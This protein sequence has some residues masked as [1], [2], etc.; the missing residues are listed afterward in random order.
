MYDNYGSRL[1][2]TILHDE[3]K[4]N[5][6]R[7][8][9]V[10]TRSDNLEDGFIE[11]TFEQVAR[12][13]NHVSHWLQA[14]FENGDKPP[15]HTTLSYIGVPDLRYNIL[16]YAAVQCG[17]KV[18]LPSP[19]NPAAVNVSLLEQTQCSRLVHSVEVGP[20]A[21]TLQG[22]VS[23][24][25]CEQLPSLNELLAASA[26]EYTY[27]LKYA[28]VYR[29][30]ILIL[31]SS[32]STGQPKPVVHTHGTFA[33]YDVRDWPTVPGRINHD[34]LCTLRFSQPDSRIYDAFP[35]FHIAGFMT[36][37]MVPLFNLTAP[38]F[39][40]PLRPPSGAL[41]AEMIRLHRPRGAIIPPSITEQLYHE[42]GGIDLFKQLDVLLFAGGPLPQV[43]GDEIS[44][45][46][47]LCQLYGSTE[48]SQIRQ[49]IPL[50]EDWS[51]IQFHPNEPLELQP[52]GD[53]MFE[54]VVF[55]DK[56]LERTSPLYHNYPDMREWRTKDLFRPHPSKPDLWKFH[57]RRDDIL[58]F[59]SGEKLNPIPMESSIT[60]VSG[61]NG[62]LVVGQGHPRAALLVEL[63]RDVAFSSDPRQEL[64]SAIDAANALLPGYGRI[65]RSMIIIADAKKPF[66]RAG[67]GTVVRRL[68]EELYAVEIQKFYETASRKLQPVSIALKPSA[69]RA[70][71]VSGLVRSILSQVS[72]DDQ[73][74]DEE[75]FYAHGM[76]SVKTVEA[77]W[78]L[79]ASLLPYKSEADL[80]WVSAEVLYRSP[81]IK[82]LSSLLL[83][84]LNNG[85]V[86]KKRNRVIEMQAKIAE[87]TRDLPQNLATLKTKVDT[88][89][90]S[91][92]VTGTTGYLGGRLLTEL[93]K[94]PRISR[95]Y[96][97][98]RSTKAQQIFEKH[99]PR[100]SGDLVF[101]HVN[102]ASPNLGLSN[103]NYTR[104]LQDCDIIVH[105]AWRVDFNLTLNSFE[106]NLQSVKHL[107]GLSATSSLRP[108]ILFISS[109][110]STGVFAPAGSPQHTVPEDIVEDLGATMD[111]GYAESK[112]VAEHV[113]Y[114]ASKV[115]IPSTII[116][117]GQISPSSA[118]KEQGTWPDGDFVPVFLRTCKASRVLASDFVD[119][120]NWVPVDQAAIIV[121]DIM[122]HEVQGGSGVRFY[123]VVHPRPRPWSAVIG[124]V[125]TWCGEGTR[126]VS[127]QKWLQALR[128]SDIGDPQILDRFP[129]LRMRQVYD[130]MAQRG[131]THEYE[132]N[133]LM[134]TSKSMA[135]LP[136]VDAELLETWLQRL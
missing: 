135:K 103:E 18:V 107:I 27:D 7:T 58:V 113:L 122:E 42:H 37:V 125:R 52:A 82:Q 36:K 64:W 3:A 17:Y 28:D 129:A 13:V 121:A 72:V 40:P 39:G 53:G 56:D 24:L 61:V 116:R 100:K 81:T 128:E 23:G 14:R 2:P 105:N 54:L 92:A 119:T 91:V 114:A 1:M 60:A 78:L 67:K 99:N 12:A 102:L 74:N 30:P 115:G 20:V 57:A 75:N 15:R 51:Y 87:Y 47:T 80:D 10:V 11:V 85:A 6:Q 44:K 76:D 90:F 62:A 133:N 126:T 136:A 4:H 101:F 55:A 86:P 73:M 45:H 124:S 5:P 9:A 134:A 25:Q 63:G 123:N 127:L 49:L 31:H 26:S 46:T 109:I 41:A 94:N 21:K 111:I 8:F 43:V 32:G 48:M 110:S 50:P 35:P 96:C 59:S 131:P 16:F 77:V 88:G 120:V 130:I 97:L 19:R 71:D 106:D 29:E 104:L 38:I 66:V 34:G 95:I 83:D 69:F 108:R 70:G 68:T 79:K 33:T 89:R 132:M 93:S 98:N 22:A 118:P 84:F 112:H 65:T 117:M